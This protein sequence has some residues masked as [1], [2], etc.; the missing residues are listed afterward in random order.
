M[1]PATLAVQSRPKRDP[2]G[3]ALSQDGRAAE[4]TA[5]ATPL[6]GVDNI[7]I[8]I[9]AACAGG[10][11]PRPFPFT[12]T[13]CP[14]CWWT[15]FWSRSHT[16]SPSGLGSRDG[17]GGANDRVRGPARRTR[18]AW[19][20]PVTLV[21]LAAFGQYQRLW[22]FVGQRDYEAVVKGVDRRHARGR[23][24]DRAAAPGRRRTPIRSVSQAL[25]GRRRERGDA[26][27]SVIALFFLL[28]LALLIGARFL[29]QLVIDG[30]VRSFRVG[31]G[32][33]RRADRRRRRRRPA[34][35]ARADPQPGSCGCGR[36][37]SSTTIRASSGSRTSTA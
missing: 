13:P 29:V 15:G 18:S 35:G 12:A 17:L 3:A 31:Q 30:R 4:A 20:V 37:A 34:G 16:T 24:R 2:H 1:R 27:G 8:T 32:S 21:V 6:S 19:V 10:S 26:A 28:A 7:V 36:S 14:S 9:P 11:D 5:E 22:T 25:H 33:P 23:R